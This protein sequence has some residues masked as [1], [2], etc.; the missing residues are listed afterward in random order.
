M[1]LLGVQRSRRNGRSGSQDSR[2]KLRFWGRIIFEAG[3]RLSRR[4]AWLETLFVELQ[5]NNQD[6]M[7]QMGTDRSVQTV[8]RSDRHVSRRTEDDGQS[9]AGFAAFLTG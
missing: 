9:M 2:N 5:H 7:Y 4:L 6:D 1:I 8:P 3:S